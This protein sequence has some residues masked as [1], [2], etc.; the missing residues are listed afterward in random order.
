M[1]CSK[2][3]SYSSSVSPFQAYTG[4]PAAAIAAAAWSCVEKILHEDQRTSAPRSTNV[5]INTPVWI[6]ICMQPKILA[7]FSGCCAWYFFLIVMSAGISLSAIVSSFLPQSA[8]DISATLKSPF[9]TTLFVSFIIS[10]F[11]RSL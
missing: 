4:T 3:Q 9:A 6:V 11:Q 5:S 2:H 8:S 10:N 1:V 7:P